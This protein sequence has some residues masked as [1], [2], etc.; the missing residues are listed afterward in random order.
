MD[1]NWLKGLRH[2]VMHLIIMPTEKCNLSCGYCYESFKHGRMKPSVRDDLQAFI[3]TRST[4]LSHLTLSWFGGEPLLQFDDMIHLHRVAAELSQA[5]GYFYAAG[6]T[7]NATL[8]NRERMVLLS[9]VAPMHFQITIDGPEEFHNTKRTNKSGLTTYKKIL[10]VLNDLNES[11]INSTAEIRYHLHGDFFCESHFESICKLVGSSPKLSLSPHFVE[12]LGGPNDQFL[13]TPSAERRDFIER[14][15][16]K[17]MNLYGIERDLTEYI[18][19]AARPNSFIVRSDGKV[20]KCTV[21]LD[22]ER[23][24]VGM[25]QDGM[26]LIDNDKHKLWIRGYGNGDSRDLACPLS[27]MPTATV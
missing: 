22:N 5:Y 14:S 24:V 27:S 19:Y 3:R 21:D 2:D 16:K 12:K 18:C 10:Q 6:V 23:N 1:D 25:L 9:N 11:D 8:L 7:T 26:L 4:T 15:V 20:S 13:F 17:I